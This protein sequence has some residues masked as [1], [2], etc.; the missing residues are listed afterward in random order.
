[1]SANTAPDQVQ[2]APQQSARLPIV[3]LA[4]PGLAIIA[5]WVVVTAATGRLDTAFGDGWS[6]MRI[7]FHYVDTGSFRLNGY[8]STAFVGQAVLAWPVLKLFPDSLIAAQLW[9]AGVAMVG[10]IAF[11]AVTRHH[12]GERATAFAGAT[13]AASPIVALLAATFFTDLPAYAAQMVCLACGIRALTKRS[14]IWLAFSM[15]AGFVAFSIR[16]FSLTAPF[17]V[18]FVVTATYLVR[19]PRIARP[20]A[21]LLVVALGLSCALLS[22]WR[23]SLPNLEPFPVVVSFDRVGAWVPRVAVT[24]GFLIAPVAFTLS[25]VTL[26]RAMS[27]WA[28]SVSV[29][30]IGAGGVLVFAAIGRHA[31]LM[32]D[33]VQRPVGQFLGTGPPVWVWTVCTVIGAYGITL[34]VLAVIGVTDQADVKLLAQ[35]RPDRL[36]LPIATVLAIAPLLVYVISSVKLPPYDRY[37]LPMVPGCIVAI[38][39]A[40]HQARARVASVPV[41]L[42]P[43]VGSLTLLGMLVVSM[44]TLVD[45]SRQWAAA[46]NSANSVVRRGVP[47]NLVGAPAAWTEYH[48]PF[49]TGPLQFGPEWRSKLNAKRCVVV[50]WGEPPSGWKVLDRRSVP[51]LKG[52]GLTQWTVVK[53]SSECDRALGQIG[54][55]VG[56]TP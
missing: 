35:E 39:A 52:R 9:A 33:L 34:L 10:A 19:R 55:L 2:Q 23:R 21:F 29:V 27:W 17:A 31:N 28:R 18:I 53:P 15:L 54:P 45:V 25:P 49:L 36:V 38:L 44:W 5:L 6:Y 32:G 37:L 26:L 41:P 13:F 20:T 22:L 42:A 40:R 8:A 48:G 43:I 56:A 12:V 47:A 7:A 51:R 1:M 3:L 46:W 30:V 14:A 4:V 11:T 16:D 50:T 24:L